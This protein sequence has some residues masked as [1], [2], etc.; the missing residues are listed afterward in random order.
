MVFISLLM[1]CVTAVR[2]SIHLN[3]EIHVA[4]TRGRGL[5][6]SDPLSLLFVLSMEYFSRPMQKAYTH[7][8]FKFH[9]GCKQLAI[10]HWMFVDDLII[11]CKADP[12]SI[13]QI[14]DTLA[15]F[16]ETTGF[17]A[18]MQKSQ[19]VLGGVHSNC[20]QNVSK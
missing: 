17:K 19:M 4:F 5:M 16:S 2:F 13:Q 11:F 15:V 8:T 9:P 1:E 7:S 14:K 10:T 3:G 12:K 18:N 20:K 6:Q